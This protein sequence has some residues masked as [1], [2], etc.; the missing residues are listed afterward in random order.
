MSKIATWSA[1]VSYEDDRDEEKDLLNDDEFILE[2]IDNARSA[3]LN[4]AMN[5]IYEFEARLKQCE[6]SS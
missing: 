6:L 3:K 2:F 5:A 1:G 4:L